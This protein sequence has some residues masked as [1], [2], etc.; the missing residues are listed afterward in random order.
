MLYETSKC[1]NDSIS[2]V[3]VTPLNTKQITNYYAF[4]DDARSCSTDEKF[5]LGE[6]NA[7]KVVDDFCVF[8]GMTSKNYR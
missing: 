6:S 3:E 4:D 8:C 7:N 1:I 2:S 5:R